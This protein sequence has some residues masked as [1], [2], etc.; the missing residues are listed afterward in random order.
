MTRGPLAE[1]QRSAAYVRTSEP[2]R[3]A[4]ALEHAG[5]T[6]RAS[7]RDGLVVGGLTTDEIGELAF[8]NR[9]RV[10]ELSARAGSLEELFLQWTTDVVDTEEAERP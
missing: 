4:T 6:A 8:T 2:E 10:H 7:G 1:L 3:L 5:A 9:L